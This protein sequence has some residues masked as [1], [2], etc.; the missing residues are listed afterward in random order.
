MDIVNGAIKMQFPALPTTIH[1]VDGHDVKLN[2]LNPS[3]TS[4]IHFSGDV[5][6][7]NA[8]LESID[9]DAG[10]DVDV[11]L[12]WL[13]LDADDLQNIK[14][15]P[16]TPDVHLSGLAWLLSI[17]VGFI[18]FGLVGAIIG[19]IIVAVVES[20]ASNIGGKLVR[21]SVTNAIKGLQA[22]PTPL[23]GV[24]TVKSAYDKEI[25]ISPDGLLSKG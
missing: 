13:P 5:T 11:G 21:D 7:I 22:W 1:N 15:D 3:L 19:A 8:I 16:G 14:A 23:K 25:D 24:G 18:T 10:F 17:L 2:S 6:V 20:I 4:A 12:E 9:V